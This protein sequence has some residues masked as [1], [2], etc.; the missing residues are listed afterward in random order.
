MNIKVEFTAQ[1]AIC[2]MYEKLTDE[3]RAFELKTVT[4]G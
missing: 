1:N 4:M 3:N 2:K